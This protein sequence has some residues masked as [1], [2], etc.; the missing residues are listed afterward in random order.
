V[1]ISLGRESGLTWGGVAVPGVR[2]V[3]VD[4]VVAMAEVRPFGSRHAFQ[5]PTGYAVTLT[6]ETIDD[7]AAATAVAAAIAG[8]EIAVVAGGHSFTAIVTGVTDAQPLD[9]VRAYQIQ[10]AKT[11]AGLRA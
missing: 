7:A 11:Q 2:D 10:M 6:V 8:T 4:Y 9:G 3:S 5:Y 1:A